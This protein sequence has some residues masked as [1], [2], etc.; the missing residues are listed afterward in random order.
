MIFNLDSLHYVAR[1][2]V[3]ALAWRDRLRGM[4][5]RRFEPEG[6]DA[7]IFPRCNAIH[8]MWMSIPIDVVFLDADAEVAGLCAGLKPWRL[9]VSCR[10]AVTV[11]ELPAGRI[12][13]SG[14]EVGHQL[15]LNSTLSPEMIEK[16]LPMLTEEE[17]EV[18]R[19]G[20][21][22][23]SPTMAKNAT[24]S[25][26]RKATGFEALMGYLYLKDEF[27]RLVELVKTGVDELALKM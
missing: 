19:R 20:R 3:W 7:M 13:E 2:P 10:R 22:A 8:T 6:I 17:A 5:G 23:K 4:I 18:Y 25:D 21:N 26:Y 15:N 9:P 12:A 14:T 16:L 24:M 11:I 1:R 27:E